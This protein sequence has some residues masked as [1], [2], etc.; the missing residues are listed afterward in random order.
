MI[1][2][3]FAGVDGGFIGVDIFFVISGYLIGGLLLSE[4]RQT[5]R[6][7][8]VGFMA[9]RARRLLPNALLTLVATLVLGL[10]TMPASQWDSLG[11]NVSAAA[12]YVANFANA[13]QA[14]GYFSPGIAAN[15]VMH[16][17]SLS[18]EEQFYFGIAGLFVVA[19][20]A[21][22]RA[23]TV[24]LALLWVVTVVSFI[25]SVLANSS[26]SGANYFLTQFRV[27]ELGLGV[28]AAAHESTM[29]SVMGRAEKFVAPLMLATLLLLPFARLSD[30]PWPGVATL[31]PTLAT[32]LFLVTARDRGP[33]KWISGLWPVQWIGRRSYSLYLWHWPVFVLSSFMFEDAAPSKWLVLLATLVVSEIAYRVVENPIRHGVIWK[34]TPIRVFAVASMVFVAFF[35]VPF[36]TVYAARFVAPER[37]KRGDMLAANSKSSSA[38]D[39]AHCF[40]IVGRWADRERCHF[41]D[42]NS[43]RRIVLIGDSH[44]MHWFDGL[45][46]AAKSL[47]YRLD[48]EIMQA[49]PPVRLLRF[50]G[51]VKGPYR[52]CLD[53]MNQALDRTISDPPEIVVVSMVPS[54]AGIYDD[55]GAIVVNSARAS[56]LFRDALLRTLQELSTAGSQV[57]LAID[58]P[59]VT[60]RYDL[61]VSRGH[62]Q[63]FFPFVRDQ[64]GGIVRS[65]AAQM[66]PNIVVVDFKDV[67]CP[68]GNECIAFRNGLFTYRDKS[69]LSPAFSASLKGRWIEILSRTATRSGVA[70]VRRPS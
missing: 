41:G 63:C 69:H 61:C 3:H 43:R 4:L 22:S 18:I 44:A 40:S 35:F 10:Y 47:G 15:P 42:V 11:R 26:N 62:D 8:F 6:I 20:V 48:V 24:V 37:A 21:R 34:A 52:E 64:Y 70:A 45:E 13:R 1:A 33:V 65:V 9:R 53:F 12:L 23:V 16:F 27:W 30:L 5:S 17:W 66:G 60:K 49:C 59:A 54:P 68:N 7:D 19:A 36:A 57:I 38:V 39:A 50:Y 28:L 14:F 56:A 55:S 25:A 46:P 29:R 32:A 31:A 58:T 67:I 2:H 51:Y